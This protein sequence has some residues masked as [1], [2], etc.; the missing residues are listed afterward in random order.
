[1]ERKLKKGGFITA[2]KINEDVNSAVLDV[3]VKAFD[4]GSEG[5][6]RGN[7]PDQEENQ[8]GGHETDTELVPVEHDETVNMTIFEERKRDDSATVAR[9]SRKSKKNSEFRQ[10]NVAINESSVLGLAN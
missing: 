6:I 9:K 1:M 8:Y 7:S 2:L 5:S 10:S 4:S 3:K